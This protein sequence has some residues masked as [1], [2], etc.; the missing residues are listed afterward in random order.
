MILLYID[1]YTCECIQPVK[2][3][4]VFKGIINKYRQNKKY[5][6]LHLLSYM[7][8]RVPDHFLSLTL[9]C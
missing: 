1:K 6:Y 7:L 9:Y 2:F 8:T 3:K 5:K 4:I